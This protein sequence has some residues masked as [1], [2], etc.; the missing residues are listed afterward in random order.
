LPFGS[1]TLAVIVLEPPAAN[2][3]PGL[4]PTTIRPTAAAPIAI[5]TAFDGVVAPAAPPV[6]LVPV[7]P[8]DVAVIVAVPDEVPALNFTMTRPP[9]VSA[10]GGCTDPSVVVNVM[11][12]PSCGGVP[13][14][15]S[16]CAMMSVVPLSG[17][18]VAAAVTVMVEL[19]GA[20]NGTLWQAAAGKSRASA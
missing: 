12:V 13:A 5:L 7:A 17:S 11:S 16:T 2:T 9:L 20:S 18:V 3:V 15:S 1:A 4:A 19:A 8:P 14:G 6:V 10:S